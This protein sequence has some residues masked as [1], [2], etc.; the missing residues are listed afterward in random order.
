MATSFQILTQPSTTSARLAT[1][2]KTW[3]CRLRRNFFGLDSVYIGSVYEE[4]FVLKYYGG[5][6]FTESYN[7]PIKLRRWFLD[8]L[9]QQIEKEN[10][11][12][13]DAMKKN[14]P[15]GGSY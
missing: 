15:K 13:E 14:E 8:R 12:V 2:S 4:F 11:A 1:F 3:R 7:L 6:S 9:A 5:W 10:K